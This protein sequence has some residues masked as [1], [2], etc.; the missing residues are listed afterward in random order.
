MTWKVDGFLI[1]Y[2][3]ILFYFISFIYL[4]MCMF[5]FVL[6]IFW[7]RHINHKV[8]LFLVSNNKEK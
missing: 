5:C 6:D 4:L 1:F 8:G 7:P 3:K 2:F